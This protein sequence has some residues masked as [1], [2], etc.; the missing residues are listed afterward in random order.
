MSDGLPPDL[1]EQLRDYID[2]EVRGGFTP[3]GEIPEAAVE[4]LADEVEGSILRPHA[5]HYT[6]AALVA[7]AE[8]QKAWPDRTDCDRLDT[9]FARLEAAGILAR[10]D[11]SCCQ[12]CGHGEMWELV[13][14][15]HAHG[16]DVRGYTFYHQQ[17]TEHAVEGYGL[18]LAWGAAEAGE[19]ALASIG[20]EVVAALRAEGLKVSWDGG[21]KK[22][23]SVSME[24]KRRR[25]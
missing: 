18:C 11:F 16:R 12:N 9:A 13:Q 25:G 24:W 7:L 15:A 22:R 5:E 17:D 21:T 14:D 8:A 4:Y 6:A 20:H 19:P 3:I 2:R 10:Q 23:I 1:L